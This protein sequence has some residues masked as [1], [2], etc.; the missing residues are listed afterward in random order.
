MNEHERALLDAL[1]AARVGRGLP[2]LRHDAR[3]S[4]AAYEHAV[5]L[6]RHPDLMHDGSDGSSIIDRIRRAGYAARLWREVVGWGFG[7]DVAAMVA[8]WLDSP[9]HAAILLERELADIGAGYVYA[10]GSAAGHYWTVD[11]AAGDGAD[12]AY[13]P[14]AGGG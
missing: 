1:N 13:I 8:W 4:V 14:W 3:L 10:P 12:S 11:M 6:S 5:D 9:G 7:G 2:P